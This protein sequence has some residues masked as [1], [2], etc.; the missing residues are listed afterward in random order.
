MPATL[1]RTDLNVGQHAAVAS[2]LGRDT[3][4]IWGPPG[5]GK[6]RTIGAIGAEWF[7]RARSLLMV[8]HTNAAV[9]QALL[10][11]AAD[12]ASACPD[13]IDT[14]KVL[15]VGEP[16]DPQLRDRTELHLQTHVARRSEQLVARRAGLVCERERIVGVILERARHLAIVEWVARGWP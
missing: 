7:Q 9:D 4:F 12:I 5:T 14:G 16:S 10:K 3:T 11:I 15:R 13:A 1:T 6:T 2:A 8:A